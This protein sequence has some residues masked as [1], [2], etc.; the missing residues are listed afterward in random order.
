MANEK[1]QKMACVIR[2]R[3]M[4]KWTMAASLAVA[5]MFGS[6]VLAADMIVPEPE[7]PVY[8]ELPEV[9]YGLGGSFYLRGSVGGNALWARNVSICCTDNTVTDMGWGYSYGVGAGYEFGDGWRADI[10]VDALSNTGLKSGGYTAS[11]RSTVALANVYYDF[12]LE[13]FG[14]HSAEGGWVGYVGGGVG[15]AWSYASATH[16][17]SADLVE[18]SAAATSWAAAGMVGVGYDMGNMVADVGYRALWMKGFSTAGGT[19]FWAQDAIAHEIRASLR[20][21]FH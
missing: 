13:D 1:S 6:S 12:S 14:N 3:M 15:K 16:P 11:L 10:T 9:D 17:T 20:Y 8:P 2:I 4:L 5:S 19:D 21:R 7:Y 18:G